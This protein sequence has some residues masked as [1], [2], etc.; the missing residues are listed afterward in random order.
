M[1]HLELEV[2]RTI[3]LALAEDRTAFDITSHACIPSEKRARADVVLKQNSVIAGLRFLP[4]IC[5]CIDPS[6]ACQIFAA[7]GE[8]CNS[9]RALAYIEGKAH[10]I[11][12]GE[13][14]L[15]NFLQ[16][17]SGIAHLT[18]QFVNAVKGF[19][20]EILDT[21]KTLPGLRAIQK[22]AVAVGGGK[23][24]RFHL[25]ERFLIKN[26]HLKLLH[27]GISSPVLEAI[28]R[29]RILQPEAK[30]EVEVETLK[31]LEEALEGKADLIMLDNM[32][33]S[34]VVEA[35]KIA[36]GKAYLEASGGVHLSNVHEYAAAGVNG[37]SIGELTHSVKAVDI[38]L[39]VEI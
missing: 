3:L 24:H 13:R 16:H 11:L 39:R 8:K 12:A 19:N 17:A 4:V 5:E 35:V 9:S 21:R 7:D 23:N 14:T 20:C 37:I 6:L 33:P 28:R 18:A 27:E 36:Q 2:R 25:E 22:Y 30:I 34:L 32:P 26:N 15:L 38:S 29:A 10:S 1:E 31:M